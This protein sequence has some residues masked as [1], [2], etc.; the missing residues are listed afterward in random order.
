MEGKRDFG[1]VRSAKYAR[2]RREGNALLSSLL[3]RALS[4]FPL[5]FQT[6]ATL[7]KRSKEPAV[8]F[9]NI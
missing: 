6:H 3:P 9:M 4:F 8:M 7:T 1:R 2:G 5:P